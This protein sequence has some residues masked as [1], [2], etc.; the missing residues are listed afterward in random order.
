MSDIVVEAHGTTG[1]LTV[2]GLSFPCV[3]G[4]SGL[5]AD[6]REGDGATPVGRF[7]LRRL[8]YRA[9]RLAAPFTAL[10]AT[11]LAPDDGWCDEPADPHYNEHVKLPYSGHHEE[12]W[13]ADR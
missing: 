3:L 9:D 5:S 12:L 6:K 11:V 13:R 7:P 2:A 8:L 10:P 4:R 1:S